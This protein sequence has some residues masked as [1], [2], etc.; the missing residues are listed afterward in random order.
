MR[1]YFTFIWLL[2]I[3]APTIG[4]FNHTIY[5]TVLWEIKDTVNDKTSYLLGTSHAFGSKFFHS[6]S[7]AYKKLKQS[8]LILLQS[9]GDDAKMWNVVKS[10]TV[11][12]EWKKMLT[13][14]ELQFIES[15]FE[16][17]E[18]QKLHFHELDLC[19]SLE[20]FRDICE[21]CGP[22]DDV[23]C[24]DD[25]IEELGGMLNIPTKGF[26]KGEDRFKQL[27][28]EYIPRNMLE[29]QVRRFKSLIKA[30][31]Q[32]SD[33]L[34]NECELVFEYKD[35]ELP[36]AFQEPC[37]SRYPLI[38]ERNNQWAEMLPQYLS[39]Q[40]CFIAIGWYHLRHECGLI[41][42]LKE[43]GYVVT[44]MHLWS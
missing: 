10:R 3:S 44:P 33:L 40:N 6:M 31:K 4:Q 13:K 15:K 16:G 29:N 43:K 19:L 26:E 7:T 35:M 12:P 37:P 27:G 34:E 22:R 14:S 5:N 2:L 11:N 38:I 42:Q 9:T 30:L 39:S 23:R 8:E 28:E 41:M 36:Y 1:F 20:Y 32:N 24:M 25:Y 21:G 17:K 18:F